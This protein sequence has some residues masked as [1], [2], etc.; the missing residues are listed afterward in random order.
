[1]TE[2]GTQAV[3]PLYCA[4]RITIQLEGEDGARISLRAK[5][6]RPKNL[7][8]GRE[9][10][11][12]T[13]LRDGYELLTDVETCER[14][15]CD[16]RRASCMPQIAWVMPGPAAARRARGGRRCDSMAAGPR[17]VTP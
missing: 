6:L 16:H 5:N 4:A 2:V 7:K 14:P 12:P 13:C 8:P 9:P 3:L 15:G 17:L 10:V 11:A 1:M